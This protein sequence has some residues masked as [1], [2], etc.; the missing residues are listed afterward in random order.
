MIGHVYGLRRS[1]GVSSNLNEIPDNT[2]VYYQLQFTYYGY[3]SSTTFPFEV[4]SFATIQFLVNSIRTYLNIPEFNDIMLINTTTHE[5]I[6]R[7][8]SPQTLLFDT[9]ITDNT[10]IE[11]RIVNSAISKLKCNL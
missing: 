4:E 5:V 2:A 11:I 6:N 3:P 7:I 9:N 1:T 8:Y 10:S